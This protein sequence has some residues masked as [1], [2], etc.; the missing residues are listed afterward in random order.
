MP[1]PNQTTNNGA[2]AIFGTDCENTS[3]GSVSA[4]S[5]V[6]DPAI[7]MATG[8][9]NNAESRKPQIVRGVS[10]Q[11]TLAAWPVGPQ[12]CQHVAGRRDLIRRNPGTAGW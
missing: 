8:M 11:A 3:S 10:R 12:H 4:F 1:K 7:S 6:F 2:I 9:P 5:T